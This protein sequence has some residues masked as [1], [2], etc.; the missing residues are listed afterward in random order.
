[1]NVL[2]MRFTIPHT[3]ITYQVQSVI[4]ANTT[5]LGGTTH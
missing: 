1:M 3:Y 2:T 4:D 5:C